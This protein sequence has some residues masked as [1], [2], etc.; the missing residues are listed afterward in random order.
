MHVSVILPSYNEA[1]NIVALV[2]SVAASIPKNYDYEII[3]VDDDSPDG[4]YK[5]V[6]Q[7]FRDNPRMIALLRTQDRGLAVSIRTGIETA[8]GDYIVVMDTDFTHNPEEIPRLLHVA[9]LYDIVSGSRFCPGGLM[10]ST[11]HY[12]CSLTFNW[13][14]R[15]ILRTQIQDNT[16]GYFAMRRT[17]LLALP[18]DRIFFG[19]GDYY[20]RLLHYAQRHGYSIVE[21]PAQYISRTKGQSKSNFIRMLF[22]YTTAMLRMKWQILRDM[23]ER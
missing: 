23:R 3:V 15:I 6:R 5:S 14:V 4:T 12:L 21:I 22:K 7:A 8:R 19:Y 11:S 20:F 9:E 13:L 2:K 17:K 10:Q 18:L 1:R 16:G